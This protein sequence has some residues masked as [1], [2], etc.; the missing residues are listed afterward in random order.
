[1]FNIMSARNLAQLLKIPFKMVSRT[2]RSVLNVP[3]NESQPARLFHLS[4]RD[5][6]QDS[7]RCSD[8]RFQV[9]KKERHTSLFRKCMAHISQLQ[10]TICDLSGPGV[11]ITEIPDDTI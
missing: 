1:M 9:D 5:F 2:L 3:E 4:F 7:Q 11:L 10:E 6:L 8:S